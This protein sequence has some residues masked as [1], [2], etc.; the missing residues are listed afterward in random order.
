MYV[1][2]ALG[3]AAVA[4][5]FVAGHALAGTAGVAFVGG[6]VVMDAAWAFKL[7]IPQAMWYRWRHRNDPPPQWEDYE[8]MVSDQQDIR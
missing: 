3:A 6:L 7:G 5:A 1:R 8:D 2:I 4:A